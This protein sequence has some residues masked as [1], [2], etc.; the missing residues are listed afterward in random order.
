MIELQESINHLNQSYVTNNIGVQIIFENISY[1]VKNKNYKS[2]NKSKDIISN[3]DGVSNIK[4]L[5]EITI[6]DNISGIIQPGE[7]IGLFGPSGSGKSTLL[8]ILAKRKSTGTI[9]GKILVNGKEI[10]DGFKKYC[11]YVT[12]EDF[13]LQTS[14]VEETLKFHADLRLPDMNEK[15]KWKR[16]EQVLKDIGLH[17]KA[18]S[19]IG[20]ILPGGTILKGLSGGEKKRVS[21]GCALVTNPSVLLLDEPTSGLDSVTALSVM[22]TLTSLTQ[23]GVTVVSSIHQPN[24][25]I[26]SLFHQI[27]VIIKGRMLYNGPNVIGYFEKLGY[28]LPN[29]TNP[30]DFCLDTSVEIQNKEDYNEICSQWEIEWKQSILEQSLN[31]TLINTSEIVYTNT[32]IFYQYKILMKRLFTDFYRNSGAF[33]TR[34]SSGII[35]GLLF[36]ACF[37]RLHP[38]QDD[39]LKIAGVIF[40]ILAVLALSPFT[41]V[42]LFLSNREIFNSERASKIYHPFPYYLSNITL[43]AFILFFVTLFITTISYCVNHLRWNFTSFIV[44]FVVYYFIIVCSDL[45][46][47]TLTNVT[48][49][50]DLTFIYGTSIAIIYLLFMGFL[51]PVNSLPKSFF[52]LHYINPLH[53]GFATAMVIQ[54]KDYELTCNPNQPCLYKNGNDFLNFYGFQDWTIQKGIPIIVLWLLFFFFCGYLAL[55]KLNKEKR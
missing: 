46:V 14:T 39:I 38:S 16:V 41:I 40:F 48:G 12:Q 32:S 23:K 26:Y 5:K 10:G 18:K 42:S 1:T 15:D 47:I 11:S 6:L 13:L 17:E 25:L 43:E 45:L 50:S 33:V 7:M 19:K 49:K 4:N 54:F 24:I 9:S 3:N 2:K 21:I 44:T 28:K 36:S 35:I 52:W 53:Y 27:M 31:Q 30:A 37:G 55:H 22:K 34:L 51:I 8:D 29:N 20:G